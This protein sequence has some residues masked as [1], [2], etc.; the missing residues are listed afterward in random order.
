MK[1]WRLCA[2]V[3][4]ET[5]LICL[6]PTHIRKSCFSG[7]RCVFWSTCASLFFISHT[8]L[9]NRP[10]TTASTSRQ[11]HLEGEKA[12]EASKIMRRMQRDEY[13]EPSDVGRK[14]DCVFMFDGIE[15]SNIELK[16]K[17]ASQRDVSVQLRK[18]I[19]LAR[20]IQE[21][22]LSFG[23]N[24]APV[25]MGDIQGFVGTF[26]R[27]VQMDEIS[28]AGE[29][30]PA[31]V[32]LPETA[33]GLEAF[34]QDESLGLI[35]NFIESLEAQGPVVKAAKNRQAL[36]LQKEKFRSGLRASPGP[37][38]ARKR[39]FVNVVTLSPAKKLD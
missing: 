32:C 34:L 20:C 38:R 18:N 11:Q 16:S 7:R 10:G 39:K 22:D 26:Y 14:V 4:I 17:N 12:L 30:T 5:E 29:V 8:A 37:Q 25:V 3:C 31:V 35:C 23:M 33:L 6:M 28:A 36:G 1:R 19:G 2:K 9:R 13:G 21:L 24:K 15:L 27:V